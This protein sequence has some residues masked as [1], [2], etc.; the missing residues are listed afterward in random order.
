MNVKRDAKRNVK[1][2]VLQGCTTTLL[3]LKMK[4]AYYPLLDRKSTFQKTLKLIPFCSSS[5]KEIAIQ[6]PDCWLLMKQLRERLR[7][8]IVDEGI[9]KN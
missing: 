3:T 5:L 6:K 4:G 9:F 7:M 1:S 2:V 8:N